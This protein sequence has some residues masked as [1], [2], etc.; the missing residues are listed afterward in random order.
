[1]NFEVVDNGFQVLMMLLAGIMSAVRLLKTGSRRYVLLVGGYSCF[2]MGTFYYVMYLVIRGNVPQ[3]FYVAEIAWL[4]AYLFLLALEFM[5]IG[6]KVSFYLPA[7]VAGIAVIGLAIL[8]DIPGHSWLMCIC[9]GAE[10]GMLAYLA[11]WQLH[12]K[13]ENMESGKRKKR[14]MDVFVLLIVFLQLAVYIVSM[15]IKDYS[16]FNVY[17]AV[18]ITLTLN[19]VSLYFL[20][21]GE[22]ENS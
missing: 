5:R 17:F 21:K 22:E 20:V 11:V 4:A 8:F 18:D 12:R 9:F 1:M 6:S 2:A 19:W 13:A 15:F 3:V 14:G 10:L 16:R 7:A